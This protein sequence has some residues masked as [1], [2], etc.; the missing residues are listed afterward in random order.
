MK[1]LS[2]EDEEALKEVVWKVGFVKISKYSMSDSLPVCQNENY[3]SETPSL[4]A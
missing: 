3:Q 4:T 2:E 1:N